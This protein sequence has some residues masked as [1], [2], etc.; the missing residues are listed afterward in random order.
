MT[1][2][3]IFAAEMSCTAKTE[4]ALKPTITVTPATRRSM[5][6]AAQL[7]TQTN[8]R[9]AAYCRVSTSAEGQQTS[10]TRQK[11][12]YSTLISEHPGWT[13]A[14]I[15]ADADASGT[16]TDHRLNFQR[17]IEDCKNGKIDY[18]I[19]KSI[20]RFARNTVDTLKY[21]RVLK[22]LSPAIGIYFEKENVDTLNATG[23]LLLTILSALAQD[24]SRSISDNVR[25]SYA[26][27]FQSGIAHCNLK[28]MMGYD[29]GENGQWLINEQQAEIVRPQGC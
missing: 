16:N 17:M 27:K 18:I 2:T 1:Q 14:G 26:K 22:Q 5:Q 13:L 29:K 6:N 7:K 24:E 25:W 28:G 12:F 8:I 19:T 21:V 4:P 20:S 11:S 15:Y 9:V 23:E 3:K 10:Y